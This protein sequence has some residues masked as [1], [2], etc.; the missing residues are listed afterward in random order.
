MLAFQLI[1]FRFAF[2][3][4]PLCF[5]LR[6]RLLLHFH[7]SRRFRRDGHFAVKPYFYRNAEAL[8]HQRAQKG[9]AARIL[10]DIRAAMRERDGEHILLQTGRRI[11]QKAVRSGV[12][13]PQRPHHMREI[14]CRKIRLW[15]IRLNRHGLQPHQRAEGTLRRLQRFLRKH[16][17]KLHLDLQRARFPFNDNRQNLP[18]GQILPDMLLYVIPKQG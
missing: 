12:F 1:P 16:G 15:K 7:K 18:V 10:Q 11:I 8:L 5:L 14:G 17:V 13:P 4:L 2:G 3:G 6:I 9:V